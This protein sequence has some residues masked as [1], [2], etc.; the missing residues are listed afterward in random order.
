M[1]CSG[2]GQWDSSDDSICDNANMP[3]RATPV[4]QGRQDRHAAVQREAV[5]APTWSPLSCTAWGVT[6]AED[7]EHISDAQPAASVQPSSSPAVAEPLSNRDAAPAPTSSPLSCTAWGVTC[8]EDD[9]DVVEADPQ[10]SVQPIPSA[11][12]AEQPSER[13]AA[14]APTWSPLSCTAWGVTCAEGDEL[15]GEAKLESAVPADAQKPPTVREAAPA[16]TW[17]PLS[18]TAWGVTCAKDNSTSPHDVVPSATTLVKLAAASTAS[19]VP[20]AESK[21]TPTERETNDIGGLFAR[22]VSALP[23]LT[24]RNAAAAPTWSP[25]SCTAW[26]VTCANSNISQAAMPSASA[27]GAPVV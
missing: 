1:Q 18:C 24:G 19:A 2:P 15:A 26:G 16:P 22:F 9:E 5:A 11:A 8:A 6:C 3:K 20:A 23:T 13:D 14:A 27:T 21:A 7:D 12:V 10:P 4:R 17:S 25:L